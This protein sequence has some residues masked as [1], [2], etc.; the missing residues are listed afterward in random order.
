MV[1]CFRIR[2][3]R[4]NFSTL[5][6]KCILEGSCVGLFWRRVRRKGL[7]TNDKSGFC[8][9]HGLGKLKETLM[10][11]HPESRRAFRPSKRSNNGSN[12]NFQDGVDGV[13][14]SPVL[15][16]RP[17]I[18]TTP[19]TT[20]TPCPCALI[21]VRSGTGQWRPF[22]AWL[23]C[24]ASSSA[25]PADLASRLSDFQVR[26]IHNVREASSPLEPERQQSRLSTDTS[27]ILSSDPRYLHRENDG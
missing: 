27:C 7:A 18:S 4:S 19:R 26:G 2:R 17:C 10:R 16:Y 15:Q 8:S 1:G 21:P 5:G 12:F 14:L 9:R 11:E 20:A 23:N 6:R 3:C 24:Y 25:H 22:L 13:V